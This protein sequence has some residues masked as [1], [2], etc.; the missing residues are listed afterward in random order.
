MLAL[1]SHLVDMEESSHI[2]T[3]GEELSAVSKEFSIAFGDPGSLIME[4]RHR[5]RPFSNNSCQYFQRGPDTTILKP[6]DLCPHCIILNWKND[7]CWPHWLCF[8]RASPGGFIWGHLRHCEQRFCICRVTYPSC[9]PSLSFIFSLCGMHIILAPLVYVRM[10]GAHLCESV[11][12]NI[13]LF[14]SGVHSWAF[15]S[16]FFPE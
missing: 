14:P 12:A 10:M 11:W 3:G 4:R 6:S 2:S 13:S 15:F 16:M 5:I 1:Y 7:Y 8:T 9:L